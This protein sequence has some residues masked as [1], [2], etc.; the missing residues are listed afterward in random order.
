MQDRGPN[1]IPNS[2]SPAGRLE[3]IS[4]PELLW[5][6]SISRRT[7]ALRIGDPGAVRTLFFEDGRI[8]QASS[9]LADDR[10]GPRLL[11][12]GLV[13]LD[14]LEQAVNRQNVGRR[15]D[16]LLVDA[17]HLTPEQLVEGLQDQIRAIVLDLFDRHKGTY[18]FD[19]GPVP[20]FEA[21]VDVD[22]RDLILEGTRSVRSLRRLQEHVGSS[23][24][25]FAIAENVDRSGLGD[26]ERQI[27]ERLFD[28]PAM[29][30]VLFDDLYLSNFEIYRGIW[31]LQVLGIVVPYGR[32][33]ASD[34]AT[35]ATVGCF[36]EQLVQICRDGAT[37][38][39]WVW[40]E[41]V[42]RS[43]HILEGRCV[44]ATS[45]DP[46]D[47]LVAYLLRRGVISVRDAD[48]ATRRMLSNKRLGTILLEQGV[49]DEADLQATVREQVTEIVA[50]TFG[51]DPVEMRFDA[52]PLPSAEPIT[53]EL[54]VE[55]LV[56][57][58]IR[59]VS[60]WARIRNGIG[61]L[62]ATLGLTRSYLDVLDRMLAG[63]EEWGVITSLKNTPTAREA[64][65]AGDL[66]DFRTCRILWG[67]LLLGAVEA[68]SAAETDE[69]LA[70]RIEGE[71]PIPTAVEVPVTDLD[72]RFADDEDDDQQPVE[73][74]VETVA[75]E[76][77][78]ARQLEA[79]ASSVWDL[80]RAS[81]TVRLTEEE[82][83][84]A[85]EEDDR[86]RAEMSASSAEATVESAEP[87]AVPLIEEQADDS[88][89]EI[90]SA[91]VAAGR[92]D[93]EPPIRIEITATAEDETFVLD[94]REM[95][96]EEEQLSATQ[97]EEL[98]A[99]MTPPTL[100]EREEAEIEA[101]LEHE[102]SLPLQTDAASAEWT[103]EADGEAE[104]A[105][106]PSPLELDR[107]GTYV[108][109]AQ[110]IGMDADADE[111]DSD[112][113]EEPTTLLNVELSSADDPEVEAADPEQIDT[114]MHDSR[115]EAAMPEEAPESHDD[116]ETEVDIE[117]EATSQPSWTP[118]EQLDEMIASFNTLQ[119]VIHRVVRTEV[120]AG[121]G[122]F[123]RSCCSLVASAELV[124]GVELHTDG[125]WDAKEL[126]AA[127]IEHRIESPQEDYDGLIDAQTVRLEEL[128]GKDRADDL[129]RRL[130]RVKEAGES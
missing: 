31:A 55:A 47:G 38:R 46:D 52:G 17:G 35:D 125:T 58:G 2:G 102:A 9:D 67:L 128:I 69:T 13:T 53:I 123:I 87:V 74:P 70:E 36:P 51:W 124:D 30:E 15:L 81:R 109:E 48:D 45:S 60:S 18:R 110:A 122:N 39:L 107:S 26:T 95:V 100:A 105:P 90:E 10:I 103:A 3:G 25:V 23:E 75:G 21:A 85:I 98:E 41:G 113:A 89:F 112:G 11:Q 34:G 84:R 106:D 119:R 68:G 12:R 8:V 126:R 7:G 37:G 83:A 117:P 63:E 88:E 72:E 108:T 96:E 94:N 16:S 80:E 71:P 93:V 54:E 79:G 129:Q 24:S 92:V 56:M 49:I 66:G 62:N 22:P 114:D 44:F 42:E 20:I 27:V 91:A 1:P 57:K 43:F 73:L 59:R 50:D 33:G 19:E 32:Q 86:A 121:A 130:E 77:P 104:E 28:G 29:L 65:R 120:G 101:A 5:S 116:A 61:G 4:F 111:I 97:T 40:H 99:D 76:Q 14:Q 64:C 115:A 127:V 6:L 78:S 118:P 82:L